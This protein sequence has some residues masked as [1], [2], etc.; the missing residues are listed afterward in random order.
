LFVHAIE[1]PDL[2]GAVLLQPRPVEA[3]WLQVPAEA[4]RIL[5]VPREVRG[6][7]VELFRDAAHVD[8]G[9][10][11]GGGFGQHH[12]RAALRGH[13][14]GPHAPAAATDHEQVAVETLHSH[15]SWLPAVRHDLAQL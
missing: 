15:T 8:A 1:A 4:G 3:R 9:A 7:A 12:A 10:A 6:V 14:G 11:Q 5:E 2:G 13:A